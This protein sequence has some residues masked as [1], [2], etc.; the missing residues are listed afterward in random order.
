MPYA[1]GASVF[2]L[3]RLSKIILCNRMSPGESIPVFP[4]IFN[5]T[6]VFNKGIAFGLFSRPPYLFPYIAAIAALILLFIFYKKTNMASS[7]YLGLI[8]GGAIGNLADRL[9]F[10]C[11]IDFLDFRVWPVFNIAD[12]AITI[13]A[14]LLA[15]GILKER[16]KH[17]ETRNQSTETRFWLLVTGYWLL[18]Y[19]SCIPSS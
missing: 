16:T 3:D 11:V 7:V 4:D 1:I 19:F 15:A 18:L 10:G 14:I 5:I 17:K 12:S 2:C 9:R 8:S 6:L 13:G